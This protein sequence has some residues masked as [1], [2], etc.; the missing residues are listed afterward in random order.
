MITAI[1]LIGRFVAE[2]VAVGGC[3]VAGRAGV[4]F[5]WPAGRVELG[6]G[7]AWAPGRCAQTV[8]AMTKGSDAADSLTSTFIVWR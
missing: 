6:V 4:V 7:V 2:A 5:V 8:N 1:L 3:C